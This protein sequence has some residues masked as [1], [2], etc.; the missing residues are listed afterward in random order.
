MEL[1]DPKQSA[2]AA[3]KKQLGDRLGGLCR[4]VRERRKP[5]EETW[6]NNHAAW[7]AV[8]NGR[9]QYKSE[10]FK[11]YIPVVRRAIERFIIR[12]VQV[13][14]PSPSFFEVYPGDE[15]DQGNGKAAESVRTY[16]MHLHTNPDRIPTRRNFAQLLRCLLLYDRA[17]VK[18]EVQVIDVPVDYAGYKGRIQ[19]VWPTQRVVD[20]FA[21]YV[22]PE[23]VTDISHAQLIFED[24]MMPWSEYD[25]HAKKGICDPIRR[26]DLGKPEWPHH[27]TMRLSHM[28]LTEP[29][30]VSQGI[31]PDSET[32]QQ[33]AIAPPQGFVALTEA[34]FPLNGGIAQAWLV[35]NVM[36]QP[37]VTR[38]QKARYP[39]APYRMALARP[40]PGEHYT[41][42]LMDDLEPLQILYNDQMN[43]GEE[44]RSIA[45][46]PPVIVDTQQINRADSLVFGPR[47]KWLMN[48]ADAVKVLAFPDVSVNAVRARQETLALINSIGGGGGMTEGQPTRGLPRAGFA[49]TSLISLAMGDI[50]DSAE[51]IEQEIA[52][53]SL[54]DHHRNTI[55]FVPKQQLMKIP[56]TADYPPKTMT[57]DDLMGHWGFRWIGTLQAQDQQVRAQ[58][59]MAG[60][61]TLAKAEPQLN[62][63]G[64]EINWPDLLKM[65]WRDGLGERGLE[66]IVR[67]MDPQRFAML[68]QRM[69]LE[70]SGGPGGPKVPGGP[71]DAAR[72][73][74][75]G[76]AEGGMGDMSG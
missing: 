58:R 33:R 76:L 51:I 35:W 8:E 1:Q 3:L 32:G 16:M 26:E 20:P 43:Q 74:A 9:A 60:V 65:A 68:Q 29:D 47:K 38:L 63:Q 12:G 61:Q 15:F 6:L 52:T 56:G 64:Y 69:A 75:R 72:T 49:V 22:W 36:D 4:S 62:M 48:G 42:G 24:V 40:L 44:S 27:H 18:N 46:V 37:R 45:A 57:I 5:R 23:T 53:P 13:L 34:W 39:I 25:A 66:H 54:A 30:A 2:S 41:T 28:G 55:A 11:H 71:E 21:F 73:V 31:Q 70:A 19:E 67:P 10:D 59:L 50:K 7:K 14:M 17:I